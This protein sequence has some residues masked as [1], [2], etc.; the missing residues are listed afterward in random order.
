[1]HVERVHVLDCVSLL[2]SL[3]PFSRRA[4]PLWGRGMD[5]A[6]VF[7]AA[8]FTHDSG[9][10]DRAACGDYAELCAAGEIWQPH[11]DRAL[12]VSAVALRFG[13][14]RDH[15]LALVYR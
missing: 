13:H 10:D 7:R 1:M 15:L 3:L 11:E 9:G 12:D 14:R 5:S 6:C 4:Y 2:L 8:H